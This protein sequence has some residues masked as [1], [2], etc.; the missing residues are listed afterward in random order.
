MLRGY[1]RL[2][3]FDVEKIANRD[4]IVESLDVLVFQFDT[5][6]TEGLTNLGFVIGPV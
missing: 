6:H 1:R 5:A 2:E 3:L 4:T